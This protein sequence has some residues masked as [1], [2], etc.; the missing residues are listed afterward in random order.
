MIRD[1]ELLDIDDD[2]M[3]L[4]CQLSGK[5]KEMKWQE[6]TLFW[7]KYEDND[8]HQT[9]VFESDNKIIGTA[10]VLV[11]NKLLHYGS[12]VG[13][14]EDVVVDN[15]SRMSGVGR[16][17]IEMCVNFCKRKMCYKAILDCSQDNVPFYE[18]CGF[19]YHENCM[20]INLG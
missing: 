18:S 4:L 15:K 6:A 13:H 9:F 16:G 14:I 17:L 1:L 19:I 7:L 12:K 20:R 2:Y 5:N 11:E 3:R 10:T 8:D